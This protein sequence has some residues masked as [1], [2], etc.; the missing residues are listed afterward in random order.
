[1]AGEA[2]QHAELMRPAR[3]YAEAL[4]AIAKEKGQL[5][6]VATDVATLRGV[7]DSD[8]AA[9]RALRDPKI[10]RTERRSM[11]EKKLF[12]G[13][14]PLVLGLLKVLVSRRREELLPSVFLAYAEVM[15]REEALLRIEVQTATPLAP[16]V[17]AEIAQKLGKATGRP[18][19]LEAVVRPEILGGMRFLIDST[20]IDASVRSRL[21]KLQKKMLAANV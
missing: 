6:A 13:R 11:I 10:G 7:F 15:E 3:R 4:F 20:L 2:K 16:E 18:L 5:A 1:M 12:P 14:H 19:R 8:P 17:Q 21:E 9:L